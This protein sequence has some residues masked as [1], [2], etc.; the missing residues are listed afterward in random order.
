MFRRASDVIGLAVGAKD[1]KIGSVE[2]LLFDGRAWTIRW[3]VIDTGDW[4]P[5]REVLLPPDK[6]LGTDLDRKLLEV[7]LT[8]T[9]IENSPPLSADAP[10]SR[11]YE[12]AIY[13]YYGWAPYWEM[14]MAGMAPLTPP[15]YAA[16]GKPAS[17]APVGDPNLHSAA[18]A[19][20]YG[21]LASDG[22]IGHV[23][24]LLLDGAAWVIRY[25]I[26]DTRNWWPG[27]KVLVA[28]SWVS[29]IEWSERVIKFDATRERVKSA[30]EWDPKSA[31]ERDYEARL[32]AHYDMPTYWL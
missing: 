29:D 5:G 11:R 22:A 9:P 25:L 4:L 14:G 23:D 15:L 3:A 18:D 21:V 26:V 20:G 12:E 16:G 1:G 30:P 13:D 8:R 2:D 10:V 32:H 24:D 6:L 28:P 19:S 7:G 31:L 27:K 17:L